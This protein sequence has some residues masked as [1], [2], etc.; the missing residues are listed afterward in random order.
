M[1]QLWA[2][3][4]ICFFAAAYLAHRDS[5]VPITIAPMTLESDKR[6]FWNARNYKLNDPAV[7]L[8][9]AWRWLSEQ[10][11]RV[12][13]VPEVEEMIYQASTLTYRTQMATKWASYS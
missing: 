7:T 2:T 12:A 6:D 11:P 9:K 1:S 4:E 10:L 13:F 5:L 3:L 8:S